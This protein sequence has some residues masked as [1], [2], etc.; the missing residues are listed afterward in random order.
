MGGSAVLDPNHSDSVPLDLGKGTF[1]AL[2]ALADRSDDF[3]PDFGHGQFLIF[4]RS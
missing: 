4:T 2:C 3:A 1:V